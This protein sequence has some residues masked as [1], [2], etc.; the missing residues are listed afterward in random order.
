[1][2]SLDRHIA[3]KL[4]R[5]TDKMA[6]ALVLFALVFVA[7]FA[8]GAERVTAYQGDDGSTRY[9]DAA[10]TW[11]GGQV[12]G[13]GDTAVLT[14]AVTIRTNTVVGTS[15]TDASVS[16][17]SINHTDGKLILDEFAQLNVRGH[18][19]LTAPKSELVI[20]KGAKLLFDSN[21]SDNHYVL[22]LKAAG[23]SVR[24]AGAPFVPQ[25][26]SSIAESQVGSWRGLIGRAGS[27]GGYHIESG[28]FKDSTFRGSYGVIDSSFDPATGFG[29]RIVLGNN[30]MDSEYKAD[31]IEFRNSGQILMFGWDGGEHTKVN[32]D[33]ISFKDLQFDPQLQS[34]ERFAFVFFAHGEGGNAASIVPPDQ[35]DKS[36]TNLVSTDPIWIHS[37][38]GYRLNHFVIDSSSGGGIFT[39]SEH[40]NASSQDHVFV[41]AESAGG[42]SLIANQTNYS[43]FYTEAANAH[44]WATN[45][46]RGDATLS[47]YWFEASD[48]DTSENGDAI[49]TNGPNNYAVGGDDIRLTVTDCGSVGNTGGGKTPTLV[50][51]NNSTG[52]SMEIRNCMA[53]LD[54]ARAIALNENGL[55]HV[56]AGIGFTNNVI[57]GTAPNAA[58]AIGNA[59]PG[60]NV[61]QDVFSEVDQNMYFNLKTDGSGGPLNVHDAPFSA[62]I[63]GLSKIQDPNYG[64]S[65]VGLGR[66]QNSLSDSPLTGPIDATTLKNLADTAIVQ[67]MKLN[68]EDHDSQYVVKNLVDYMATNYSREMEVQGSNVTVGPSLPS[69][70]TSASTIEWVVNATGPLELGAGGSANT[71]SNGYGAAISTVEIPRDASEVSFTHVSEIGQVIFGLVPAGFTEQQP[72]STA[73]FTQAINLNG[74]GHA[75]IYEG[76]NWTYHGGKLLSEDTSELNNVFTIKLDDGLAT[77]FQG[78]NEIQLDQTINAPRYQIASGEKVELAIILSGVNTEIGDV[79]LRVAGTDTGTGPGTDP[80]TDPGTGPG[81]GVVWSG[82]GVPSGVTLD[83]VTGGFETAA[84]VTEQYIGLRSAEGVSD[85]PYVLDVTAPNPVNCGSTT[86]GGACVLSVGLNYG[87]VSPTSGADLDHYFS[88]G[89]SG[90]VEVKVRDTGPNDGWNNGY[91]TESTY[92]ADMVFRIVVDSDNKASYYVVEGEGEAAQQIPLSNAANISAPAGSVTTA[93]IY[94]AAYISD[95]GKI[96][97]IQLAGESGPGTDPGDGV[98]SF[99]LGTNQ[100]LVPWLRGVEFQD[101]DK[102]DWEEGQIGC[103]DEFWN[104]Y[105]GDLEISPQSEK[106]MRYLV[107]AE[108]CM[109]GDPMVCNEPHNADGTWIGGGT[110]EESEEIIWR[111][112]RGSVTIDSDIGGEGYGNSMMWQLGAEPSGGYVEYNQR[113]GQPL[114]NSQLE[115]QDPESYWPVESNGVAHFDK[116]RVPNV[117]GNGDPNEPD[118]KR[119]QSSVDEFCGPGSDPTKVEGDCRL[120]IAQIGN[121]DGPYLWEVYRGGGLGAPP[122][123]DSYANALFGGVTRWDLSTKQDPQMRGW[124]LS[125]ANAAGIPHAACVITAGEIAVGVVKHTVCVAFPNEWINGKGEYVTGEGPNALVGGASHNAAYGTRQRA[126]SDT[127]TVEG[128]VLHQP[129]Y[130][131]IPAENC[132]GMPGWDPDEMAVGLYGMVFRLKQD[133]YIDP[134][135]PKAVR[136]IL[137]AMK[138]YGVMHM[139]GEHGR[140]MLH[141][142]ND[143]YDT[144]KF[145]GENAIGPNDLELYAKLGWKNF[146]LLSTIEPSTVRSIPTFGGCNPTTHYRNPRYPMVSE[147]GDAAGVGPGTDPGT[148]PDPDPALCAH[149]V[150]EDPDTE[151]PPPSGPSCTITGTA[152]DDTLNGTSGADVICGLGGNDLIYGGGGNDEIY[153]DAGNDTI[154]GGGGADVIEGGEGVDIIRGQGGADTLTGGPGKDKLYGGGGNDVLVGDDDS[155]RDVLVG[156]AGTDTCNGTSVDTIRTC[157]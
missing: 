116:Y 81:V 132:T 13:V 22:G 31:H 18:L 107:Q 77:Y 110:S 151:P 103:P 26:G 36:I 84:G 148:D 126:Y 51:Y 157:E 33:S 65:I 32:L 27:A 106:Y 25:G 24:F 113:L 11:T 152:G 74:G 156:Q 91:V 57:V 142:S 96:S 130:T 139:D 8:Q 79:E 155:L 125:S 41:A 71:G 138:D 47:K 146:D 120:M 129:S 101:A 131:P 66:W 61:A 45:Q 153:G 82:D 127:C 72:I 85:K 135:W 114:D 141:M 34:V 93:P 147:F 39:T 99:V 16:A 50:S 144:V 98:T 88:F 5:Y 20:G 112:D 29:W 111:I 115:Y 42:L 100:N 46:L 68:D 70:S 30:P 38:P 64:A 7:D 150:A 40:G 136:V 133:F 89:S 134:S 149:H 48:P 78:A 23:Q 90:T 102:C 87:A 124:S 63:D 143:Y 137:Q 17:I 14:T 54:S 3:T 67:L 62:G 83:P 117:G 109:G 108:N 1:M 10:S 12:P 121:V 94:A 55:T 140:T 59:S 4:R 123:N 56:G 2:S 58:H 118:I 76:E 80:G 6:H 69:Q 43:Y 52:I 44:G 95:R 9:W 28:G 105:K 60:T 92:T 73:S 104:L 145:Q 37:V 75:E 119:I 19:S 97:S 122:G 15:Q 35:D 86:S 49:L 21:G 154:Y 53:R 128:E